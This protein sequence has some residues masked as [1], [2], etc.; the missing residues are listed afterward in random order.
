MTK[1]PNGCAECSNTN[2]ISK[3]AQST[4]MMTVNCNL[5]ELNEIFPIILTKLHPYLSGLT[6][7]QCNY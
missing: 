5:K 1:L 7:Y 3:D 4:T 2:A 6:N